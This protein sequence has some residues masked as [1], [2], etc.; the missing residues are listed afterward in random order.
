MT[1]V[2]AGHIILT[3]P[4]QVEHNHIEHKWSKSRAQ[5]EHM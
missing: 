3:P 2:S 5:V 4:Q 1:S